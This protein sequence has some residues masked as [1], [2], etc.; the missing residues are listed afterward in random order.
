MGLLVGGEFEIVG[1]TH[2][3]RTN[4]TVFQ[5]FMYYL[6][7]FIISTDR[8]KF[9]LPAFLDF[10]GRIY[11][12]GVLHFHERDLARSL[13]VFSSQ[14]SSDI[15]DKRLSNVYLKCG[16]AFHFKKFDGYN[17][18]HKWYDDEIMKINNDVDLINLALEA[19]DQYQFISKVITIEENHYN[20]I[21][22][23]QLP[24]TQ[25]ASASAYQIMSYLLLDLELALLTNLFI[26]ESTDNIQDIYSNCLEELKNYSPNHLKS[27]I[28][29]IVINENSYPLTRTLIKGIL[30][31]LIYGKSNISIANDL[32]THYKTV[33]NKREC[34]TLAVSIVEYF[35]EKFPGIRNLMN[36]LRN[37]GWL[38]SAMGKPV[39]YQVPL[40]KTVQDYVKSKPVKIWLYDSV[41]KKKRQVTLRIPTDERDKRKSEVSTFVN[42]IHQKDA[43]IAMYMISQMNKLGAPIYTVHDNFITTANYA[44]NLPKLYLGY[45]YSNNPLLFINEFIKY[46]LNI[47]PNRITQPIP[48]KVLTDNLSKLIPKTLSSSE[49]A[50]WIKR[51]DIIIKSYEYYIEKTY[52]DN[53]NIAWGNYKINY[54]MRVNPYCL[55]L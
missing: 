40:Y 20:K 45:F 32:Y 25:D 52:E 38:C 54:I 16:A 5:N 26:C 42:F 51:I 30:M 7:I 17:F 28:C 37:I 34:F 4:M 48:T 41:L 43:Y 10:R 23:Q 50:K 46:N 21:Q 15:V 11:R 55:H 33:L 49:R 27:E 22:K 13:I 12:S 47:R 2:P 24:I 19:K 39:C 14:D 53:P 31:P 29:D 9:Y 18:A 1:G 44:I 35:N 8:Y 3:N 36:L 6:L